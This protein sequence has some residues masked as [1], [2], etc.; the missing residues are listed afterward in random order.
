MALNEAGRGERRVEVRP[1]ILKPSDDY[2]TVH[3]LLREGG[4]PP[5][6][7][8]YRIALG[9]R[10]WKV[11]DIVAENASLVISYRGS[12]AGEIARSGID[13]LIGVIED[14]NRQG[15]RRERALLCSARSRGDSLR[16][17]IGC[18]A[19][20][21]EASTAGLHS[22]VAGDRLRDGRGTAYHCP[23][24]QLGVDRPF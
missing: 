14:R 1:L 15:V 21:T 3:T 11:T 10:V 19:T 16:R 23:L 20:R 13:G 24:L 2:V 18:H 8:D 22:T 9:D 5:I 17:C 4:R 12:F 6:S 7:I